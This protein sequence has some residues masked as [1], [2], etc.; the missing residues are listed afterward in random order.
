MTL[1]QLLDGCDGFSDCSFEGIDARAST[2]THTQL[3]RCAKYV[4]ADFQDCVLHA[5][6]RWY[7]TEP[8]AE[9]VKEILDAFPQLP[10]QAAEYVANVVYC[11][12]IGSCEGT[13]RSHKNCRRQIKRLRKNPAQCRRMSGSR[14]PNNQGKSPRR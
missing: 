4:T 1:E 11:R 12:K 5:M 7:A 13:L 10:D 6:Q 8:N 2:D 9:Q 14:F 3:E